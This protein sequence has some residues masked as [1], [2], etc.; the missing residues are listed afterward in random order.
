MRHPPAIRRAA[1]EIASATRRVLDDRAFA[2][3]LSDARVEGDDE[4]VVRRALLA[5]FP[6]RL[7]RR[8]SAGSPRVVL[9]SGHG[10]VV[11]GASVVIDGEFLLALDVTAGER[12]PG[13]EARVRL[14]SR[15]ERAW[16]PA[17]TRRV[18]HRFDPGTGAVRAN[19]IERVFALTIAERPVPPDPEQAFPL[20]V[21]AFVAR[22]V[23]PDQAPIAAR[24]RFAGIELDLDA[25]AKTTCAGQTAL[26]ALAIAASIG[27]H[28]RR[29]LS[30]L[31]PETLRLPSGRDTKLVY[32]DEETVVASVKLQELFGL[33]DS[34]KVGAAGTPVVFELLA[35]NGRP[36]QTTRDLRS[37][38]D[39]TYPEVRKE[40]RPRYPRHPWPE[41]PWTAIATH[42]PKPRGA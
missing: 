42:R 10:G 12:G 32:R 14:A 24:L 20:L 37:F 2:S 39:K 17:A 34:P 1:E 26:P 36:V 5:G 7:S 3:V 4:T 6:D 15:V 31:A 28:E 23:T 18:E 22:G 11:D 13:A 41:D 40:L 21:D 25:I 33:A 19:E 29:E 38:W 27:H 16:L 8:R 30:R 9:A 35:P